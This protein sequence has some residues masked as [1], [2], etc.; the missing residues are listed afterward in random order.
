MQLYTDS[1]LEYVGKLTGIGF[2]MTD[3]WIASI[4]LAGLN[5]DYKPF[6]MGLEASGSAITPDQI[7]TK[8]L[9]SQQQDEPNAALV[10]SGHRNGNKRFNGKYKGPR[11]YKCN[12]FGH[13]SK[14]CKHNSNNKP[15][16]KNFSGK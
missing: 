2:K 8:L 12:E 9:D 5:D 15:S 1:I 13:I 7:I 3:D 16:N 6:I 11:C 4:I 10:A 14:N